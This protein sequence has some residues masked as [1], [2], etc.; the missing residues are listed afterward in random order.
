MKNS[1]SAA[2]LHEFGK[3]DTITYTSM[4]EV[5]KIDE[6]TIE[7]IAEC[8]RD[9]LTDV[10]GADAYTF[11]IAFVEEDELKLIITPRISSGRWILHDGHSPFF[12]GLELV[13]IPDYGEDIFGI[14][15]VVKREE[16]EKTVEVIEKIKEKARECALKFI[17]K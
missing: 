12:I 15:I 17:E 6:N 3:H 1:S 5:S 8:I 16:S 2:M 14:D 10:E 7:K 9:S 4:T 13:G 11:N